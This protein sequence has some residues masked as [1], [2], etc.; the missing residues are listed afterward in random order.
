MIIEE[1]STVFKYLKNFGVS[2]F[3]INDSSQ[4]E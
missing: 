2:Y 3:A 1:D 4:Q